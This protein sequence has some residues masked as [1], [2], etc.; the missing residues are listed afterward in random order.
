LRKRAQKRS[1]PARSRVGAGAG[2]QI[3]RAPKGA[4]DTPGIEGPSGILFTP[5]RYKYV[6]E[7]TQQGS[8]EDCVF[9]NAMD[10]GVG[11]ESLVLFNGE[12]ASIIMNKFPYNP[13]HI[14]AIPRRH[15]H[16]M[17]TLSPEEFSELHDL[18][19]RGYRALQKVFRP[20]GLNIGLNLGRV[21]GAGIA[22]HM[23]YHLVPR[24]MGDTNFMPLIGATKVISQTLEQTYEKLLPCFR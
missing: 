11:F 8:K 3:R 14:M 5:W 10:V 9:C 22:D 4:P 23:H 20:Q 18:L 21:A 13:G 17:D 19:L 24:W 16:E 12:H 1:R 7:I 6:T 15:T 2:V